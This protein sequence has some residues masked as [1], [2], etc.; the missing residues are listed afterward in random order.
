M[1]EFVGYENDMENMVT[2]LSNKFPAALDKNKTMVEFMSRAFLVFR[3]M[4]MA[5]A[6]VR[7]DNY[8][9][10]REKTFGN[11][12]DQSAELDPKLKAQIETNL[13]HILPL[14]LPGGEVGIHVQLKHHNTSLYN[15][16][17]TVKCWH[18]HVMC[19]LKKDIS[20]AEKG[21]VAFGNLTDVG[22]S[23]L[24]I[25]VPEAIISAINK[26]MP[27]RLSHFFILKPP[28]V[29]RFLLSIVKM[30]LSSKLGQRINVLMDEAEF[31]HSH[32][33]PKSVLPLSLGGE[34]SVEEDVAYVRGLL[35]D[36]LAV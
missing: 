22:L 25:K 31:Q 9:R 12:D 14:R 2:S 5:S 8:L 30:L 11:L 16:I 32:S 17:D 4:D 21:F 28:I 26:C 6:S 3:G 29:A 20:A 27:V 34:L 13:M 19:C 1:A 18:Y 36:S 35:S 24:D 33:I 7:L 10:W 15:S 23:N